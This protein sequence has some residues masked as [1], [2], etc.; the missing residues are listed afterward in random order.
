MRREEL[1]TG[2]SSMVNIVK[3]PKEAQRAQVAEEH[4]AYYTPEASS[5]VMIPSAKPAKASSLDAVELMYEYY[6][7]A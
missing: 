1:V 2:E 5:P 7:V 4:L 6:N 3:F